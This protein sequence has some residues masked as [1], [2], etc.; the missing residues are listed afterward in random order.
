L[1]VLVNTARLWMSLGHHDRHGIWHLD[2]VTG[3]DEYTAIVND[4]AFTNLVAAHNLRVAA[5]T[6]RRHPDLAAALEVDSEETAAW[7]DAAAA[8]HIAFE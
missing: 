7:R 3:P 2:G 4:N 5:Q 6:C 8:V 1:K